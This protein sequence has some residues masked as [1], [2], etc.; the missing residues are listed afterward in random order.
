MPT[1]ANPA[2][3]FFGTGSVNV[4]LKRINCDQS[5]CS[6]S[7]WI[8]FPFIRRAQST[9]SAAPTSTF[10]GSQPRSAHVPPNG[11]ESTTATCHPAARH[12]C[13][14]ADA[15]DPVPIAITSNFLVTL[16]LQRGKLLRHGAVFANNGPLHLEAGDDSLAPRAACNY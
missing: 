13:A 3:L 1:L 14:T 2:S 8:P 12:R 9:T 15:A 11:R 6:C 16:H 4:R 5:I 10:L 7:A